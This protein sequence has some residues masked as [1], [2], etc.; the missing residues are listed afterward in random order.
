MKRGLT[1]MKE[2][3]EDRLFNNLCILIREKAVSVLNKAIILATTSHAGQ[4]DKGGNPYILHPLRVM[5]SMTTEESR[6]VAVLHDVVE[7]TN[8]TLDDLRQQGFSEEIVTAI[9][10]LTRKNDESYLQFIKRIK[11]NELAKAVK[12]ADISDNKDLSRIASPTKTDLARIEKYNKA[13]SILT[14]N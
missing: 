1:I 10:C 3:F 13:L 7:D 5:L 11:R 2:S 8:I 14:V 6:I 9:D 4:I 12:I